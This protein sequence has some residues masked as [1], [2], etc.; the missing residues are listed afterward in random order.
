MASKEDILRNRV[1]AF[2]ETHFDKPKTF[3]VNYFEDVSVPRSTLFEI[4]K[5]KE[6]EISLERKAVAKIIIKSGIK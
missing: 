6:D 2:Q 1:Y 4:L 3:T 5:R